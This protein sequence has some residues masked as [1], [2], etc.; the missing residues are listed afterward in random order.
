M[1]GPTMSE[2]DQIIG[3]LACLLRL[4]NVFAGKI[5]FE[6]SIICMESKWLRCKP[7]WNESNETD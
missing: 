6:N 7:N 5:I 3:I 2:T 4:I 1:D